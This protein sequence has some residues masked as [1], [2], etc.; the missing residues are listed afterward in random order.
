MLRILPA[1]VNRLNGMMA[2]GFKLHVGDWAS[3]L[4]TCACFVVWDNCLRLKLAASGRF[5]L[6]PLELSAGA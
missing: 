3:T 5:A 1:E 4:D 2:V 6:F